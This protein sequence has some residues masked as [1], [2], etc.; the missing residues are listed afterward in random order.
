VDVHYSWTG[1]K[2]KLTLLMLQLHF[3]SKC[4]TG[5]QE[6]KFRHLNYI[7]TKQGVLI[8]EKTE[9]IYC[10]TCTQRDEEWRWFIFFGI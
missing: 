10:S 5:M 8:A 3:V 9:Y 2:E 1:W 6:L 4:Q 7:F